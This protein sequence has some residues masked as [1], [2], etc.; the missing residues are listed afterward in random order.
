MLAGPPLAGE[1]KSLRAVADCSRDE[2]TLAATSSTEK[3]VVVG[4]AEL[5]CEVAVTV[6]CSESLVG[7]SVSW[8]IFS[9]LE[10]AYLRLTGLCI[11][12]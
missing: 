3:E 6:D 4:G 1:E 10:T 2:S 11:V 12:V 8:L 9:K 7:G 5:G